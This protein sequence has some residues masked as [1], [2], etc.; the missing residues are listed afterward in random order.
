MPRTRVSEPPQLTYGITDVERALHARMQ[1]DLSF[2]GQQTSYASHNT[3]AFAAKFPPQ[4]P[5]TFIEELT[6]AGERVLD[7]MA[8]SGTA[9][10]EAALAG[11]VGIGLDIDPLAA[12]I[13]RAKVAPLESDAV[14]MLA[15]SIA[16]YAQLLMTQ[17]GAEYAK[18]AL[19]SRPQAD[20]DFIEYWFEPTTVA[21]L[22]ALVEAIRR[23]SPPTY[24]TFFE[25]LFSSIII[26][27]SGGVSL[28]RDLAH[29]R[30]HKVGD[31]KIKSAIRAFADKP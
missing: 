13:A 22:A 7:P 15:D 1:G 23:L 9:L 3:H 24:R 19:A 26:T 6:E 21:E 5:K 20:R 25:V 27:K 4:L 29:T 16:D 28:A 11:R 30:P 18:S 14:A 12:R 17:H 31:K 2:K 10:V 8:G